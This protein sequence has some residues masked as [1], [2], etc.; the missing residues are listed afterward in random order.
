MPSEMAIVLAGGR[1][2]SYGA[3]TRHRAK[4]ALPFAGFYRLIDFCL[5]NLGRSEITHVGLILQYLPASLIEHV[6]VGEWWDLHG[7]GRWLKVMPPFIGHGSVEWFNGTADAIY[8]NV[9]FIEDQSP[10]DV[11]I[12]SG[13]HVYSMDYRP[14]LKYHREQDADVTIVTKT[15]PRALCSRRFGYMKTTEDNE[16]TEYI[17]KPDNP[18]SQVISTGIY[19]FKR[20]VLLKWLDTN[21]RQGKRHN[22]ASD[23]LPYM[24][25]SSRMM[26]YPFDGYWDYLQ[27]VEAYFH[28]HQRLLRPQTPVDLVGW[29]VMTNLRD[30]AF[31]DRV[32][33]RV[34]GS[35]EVAGSMISPGTEI[36]GIVRGSVLSPG[37]VV[38]HGAV[39]EDCILMHDTVVRENA[40]LRRVVADKDVEFG[41]GCRV[42]MTRA[43]RT[44][45]HFD[46]PPP[47]A[48]L[49][50]VGKRSRI[51]EG[52]EVP[53]GKEIA[54]SAFRRGVGASAFPEGEL[55]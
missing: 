20:D 50:V 45:G 29:D 42:G 43:S 4:A 39:V 3:L 32:S 24:V 35:A 22:L 5:S 46:S 49:T 30:R 26:A 12:L 6:G 40:C 16:I 17:E 53:A 1:L 19:V 28:A 48:P 13:E 44:S 34:G 21:A 37:V 47:L 8:Q 31:N 11:L 41:K 33:A 25:G 27:D 51:D 18:P 15:M 52:G 2:D 54:Q 55:L 10:D 14:L 23:I 7:I 9:N 38:E 36:Q